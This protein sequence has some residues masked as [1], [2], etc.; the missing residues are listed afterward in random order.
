MTN[1]SV[2]DVVNAWLQ[3]Q[4]AD[5]NEAWLKSD[6]RIAGTAAGVYLGENDSNPNAQ[7]IAIYQ[8]A[9]NLPTAVASIL[10]HAQNRAGFHPASTS[11]DVLPAAFG[12]Y[13]REIDRTP[14]LHLK[15]S[16]SDKQK[17]ESKD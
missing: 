17:F 1:L 14:F 4:S 9:K 8:D 13:V 2:R 11:A 5:I 7:G 12:L 16:S 10:N 15:E 6:A 3:I